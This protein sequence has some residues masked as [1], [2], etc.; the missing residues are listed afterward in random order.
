MNIRTVIVDDE[1]PARAELRYLLSRYDDIE[2]IGEAASAGEA[3]RLLD[4]ADPDLVFLDIQM[5]GGNGFEVLHAVRDRARLP[6]VV[7]ATAYDNHAVKAFEERA[8]DYILKP[9][10]E[11][12]LSQT[13]ERVRNLLAGQPQRR[14]DL[15]TRLQTLLARYD[16]PREQVKISVEKN[17]RI[18]LLSPREIIYCSCES[19]GILIHTRAESHL[20]YGIA[21]MDRLA[22]HLAAAP[23][24][25]VHRAVLVNLD[26]IREFS[27][28]FNGK[29]NLVMNDARGT[30]I[31]VSRSRV[32]A[33]K[34]RVGI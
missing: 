7:F 9:F 8:I 3:I 32:K 2:I 26:G 22:E 15:E 20:L 13:I 11:K 29:Y 10:A 5:P 18:Q 1:Q 34:E 21:T 16:A 27:P 33:F 12:R 4:A 28:W 24:F 6:L 19:N 25:R 31:T 23:F 17:G 30:E 14:D